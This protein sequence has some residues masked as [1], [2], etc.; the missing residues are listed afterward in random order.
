MS[1]QYYLILCIIKKTFEERRFFTAVT[2]FFNSQPKKGVLNPS[3]LNAYSF[4]SLEF[5]TRIFS[6]T[7]S[8]PYTVSPTFS[9]FKATLR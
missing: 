8:L 4:K 2:K 7:S 6:R 3:F 1:T 9:S 5:A